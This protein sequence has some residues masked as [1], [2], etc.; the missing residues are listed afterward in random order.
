MTEEVVTD[1]LSNDDAIV[2]GQQSLPQLLEDLTHDVS[3]KVSAKAHIEVVD[4]GCNGCKGKA[5]LYICPA[6][7]F[8]QTADG[9]ILFNY[10][11]CFECGACAVA[12]PT[13][14]KWTYPIG[15]FGVSFKYG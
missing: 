5:C 11:G 10:E 4:D 12:C 14:V 8:I 9:G 3:F 2:S 1:Q 6:N 13:Y 7:L 15:G